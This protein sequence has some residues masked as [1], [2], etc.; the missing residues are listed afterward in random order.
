[1]YFVLFAITVMCCSTMRVCPEKCVVRQF[2]H[3]ETII[4]CTNLDGRA[5]YTQ[6]L[7]YKSVQCV[8]IQNNTRLNQVQEKI[9][10]LK[11][12]LGWPDGS[13]G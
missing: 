8:T 3:C 1:M 7:G 5:Y 11:D 2:R 9:M 6:R 4:E 10:H 13:V 12:T